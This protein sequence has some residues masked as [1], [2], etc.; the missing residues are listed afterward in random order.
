MLKLRTR[1]SLL[2]ITAHPDYED[3]GN[4]RCSAHAKAGR[5][6]TERDVTRLLDSLGLVRRQELLAAN[7]YLGMQQYWTPVADFCGVLDGGEETS[8]CRALAMFGLITSFRILD[9]S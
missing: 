5:R 8:T 3:G 2:M 6:R 9:G 4:P 7:R 1:A